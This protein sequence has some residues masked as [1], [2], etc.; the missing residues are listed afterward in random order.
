MLRQI[1]SIKNIGKLVDVRPRG[2]N[3][4]LAKLNIYYAQNGS[5]KTT[6]SAIFRSLCTS[7]HKYIIGKKSV[8][9]DGEPYVKI[10][11]SDN[12]NYIFS[13]GSWQTSFPDIEIFDSK[14][15]HENVFRGSSI[16]LNHRRNLYQFILG[17][18]GVSLAQRL[19]EIDTRTREINA[20]LK[21]YEKLLRA[22]IVGEMST[23][24]FLHLH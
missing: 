19:I 1:L 18:H 20:T 2:G 16:D 5:G 4:E 22:S 3:T 15:I 23:D 13:N 24:D 10:R 6:L 7:E 11:C 9:S 8:Y 17:E 14:F 21:Q 12:S